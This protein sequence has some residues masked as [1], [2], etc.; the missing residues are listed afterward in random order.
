M[1]KIP[2]I[3]GNVMIKY[4]T[5]K[6]FF[7]IN[8]KGSHVSLTNKN[9]FTTVPAG[10]T[11]LKIGTLLAILQDSMITREEFVKDY[12]IGLVK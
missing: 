3:S 2:R 1:T 7:V 9:R 6:E 4:L 10:N 11:R 12:N 5:K 8:R